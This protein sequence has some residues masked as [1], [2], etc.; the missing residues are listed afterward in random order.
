LNVDYR[1]ST[2]KMVCTYAGKASEQ[3]DVK[4]VDFRFRSDSF[5]LTRASD[6]PLVENQVGKKDWD[7]SNRVVGFNVDIGPQ[8]QG[9]FK[10]FS[11]GQNS[12]LATSESLQI[13]NQMANQGGNRGG[14][15][16]SVSLY[17]LY[18]NRSYTC[19]VDM[20]GNA[21]IQ[22]TMYF[23]LRNVPMFSGSYYIT[24]VSH[25]I[26]DSSFET[27]F[28][29]VRQPVPNLPKIDNYIQNLRA[30]LVS[31]ITEL[32]KQQSTTTSGQVNTN[33]NSV[34][35]NVTKNIGNAAAIEVPK[36]TNESCKPITN[37]SNYSNDSNPLILEITYKSLFDEI[38]LQSQNLGLNNQK[39]KEMIILI[40]YWSFVNSYDG[41][42]KLKVFGNNPG[43]ISIDQ[44][45]GTIGNQKYFCT[46]TTNTIPYVEFNSLTDY[47]VFLINRWKDRVP[48]NLSTQIIKVIG[49]TTTNTPSVVEFGSV[50]EAG[51]LSTE[52]IKF[53]YTNSFSQSQ[54]V[55]LESY[56][57]MAK[58]SDL[59]TYASLLGTSFFITWTLIKDSNL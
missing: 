22:P 17:N 54:S 45:W 57:K 21:L 36:T 32:I 53:C 49:E 28:E 2:A 39:T 10:N 1:E 37:Y 56:N 43:L 9:V 15:T 18:K 38:R 47:V 35:N 20:L 40:F 7:K 46:T 52:I 14:A 24:S 48:S 29:G 58:S 12:S 11:V 5:D 19:N 30:N 23:N 34:T 6:N 16:Q 26:T 51:N 42:D 41:K 27:S 33:V 50:Q 3:P 25:Q 44:Y 55:G 4:S 31:K 8:N 59:F 13:L